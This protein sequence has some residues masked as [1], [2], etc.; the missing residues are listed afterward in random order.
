MYGFTT[1]LTGVT[2]VE[3]IARTI[4]AL[5][6]EGFGV[7]SDIDVQKA[8]KEKL[9]AHFGLIHWPLLVTRRNLLPE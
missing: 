7:L 2:F 3:A 8:M 5:Q 1:A 6:A 9:V 4:A